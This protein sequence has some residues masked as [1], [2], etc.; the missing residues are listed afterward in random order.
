[1]RS[2]YQYNKYHSNIFGEMN[3]NIDFLANQMIKKKP[4]SD[5]INVE[6]LRQFVK[7]MS[8][9]ER[10]VGRLLTLKAFQKISVSRRPRVCRLECV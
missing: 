5:R 8:G 9:V 10:A 6:D 7:V 1:M 2:I 3:F 4:H